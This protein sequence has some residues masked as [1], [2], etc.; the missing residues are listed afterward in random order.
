[1]RRWDDR[2]FNLLQK[3]L[4]VSLLIHVLLTLSFSFVPAPERSGQMKTRDRA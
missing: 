1:M 2:H 4:L 3:C